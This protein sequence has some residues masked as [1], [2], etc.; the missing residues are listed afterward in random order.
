[1][2]VLNIENINRLFFFLLEAAFKIQF[3]CPFTLNGHDASDNAIKNR[4]QI[5]MRLSVDCI[6]EKNELL[7]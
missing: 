4:V 3:A 6:S 7:N 1:M 2:I 5:K